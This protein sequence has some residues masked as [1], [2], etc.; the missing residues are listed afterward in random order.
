MQ[1]R[2]KGE[3]IMHRCGAVTFLMLSALVLLNTSVTPESRPD[4][5]FH[6]DFGTTDAAVVGP[7]GVKALK[8]TGGYN[9]YVSGFFG[10]ALGKAPV[11]VEVEAASPDGAQLGVRLLQYDA[12]RNK[13]DS[14]GANLWGKTFGPDFQTVQSTSPVELAEQT[15]SV[16][17]V[18]Y[19]SN[20]RGTLF[21]K[22][23]SVKRLPVALTETL[24]A[25]L[26]L[27]LKEEGY[28]T[29]YRGEFIVGKKPDERC[30]YHTFRG[31]VMNSE[32]FSNRAYAGTTWVRTEFDPPFFPIGPIIYGNPSDQQRRAE[33][34]GMT[35]EQYFEHLA[36]DVKAHGGNTIYYANLTMDPATFRLAVATAVRQGLKIFAQLTGDLYL[37]PER[38]REHYQNVTMPTATRI[39]PQYRGLQGVAA[40]MPKEEPY[41][42]ELDLLA[43]YRAKVRKLDPT[44]AI[45]TL[46]NKLG[47][48][49]NDYENLPEW[50]G[51]DRY[52]FRCLH[53]PYGLLISTPKDMAQRLR[54]EINAF[55]NEA[56]KRGR[57]LLYVLQGY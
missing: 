18:L 40:W 8:A 5:L 54:T 6:H 36:R 55:Y 21:L 22:S 38:G 11:A 29:E 48:M 2:L 35:L 25:E 3:R 9:V 43:E 26:E 16:R 30:Y 31:Q 37:R 47:V 15:D 42:S 24:V 45:Y 23:V 4:M 20:Q 51:L 32:D 39:L 10:Q 27:K 56:Q 34:L 49:A 17:V 7:G 57:P 33:A 50:F 1:L 52:R 46:H 28:Q 41:S 13:L 19:R 44:H 12:D 14:I 53:G